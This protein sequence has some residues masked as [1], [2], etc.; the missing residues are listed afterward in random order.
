MFLVNGQANLA[1]RSEV[2]E[3]VAETWSLMG[4]R[5]HPKPIALFVIVDQ[6]GR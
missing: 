1:I 5:C 4:A 6:F 2:G 3:A